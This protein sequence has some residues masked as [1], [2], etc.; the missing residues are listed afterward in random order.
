MPETLDPK[1]ACC[2][3]VSSTCPGFFAQ[4]TGFAYVYMLSH[5]QGNV[6]YIYVCVCVGV[7]ACVYACMYVCTCAC[8]YVCNHVGMSVRVGSR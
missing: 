1:C 8:V 4:R 3:A 2:T 6:T 7:F 5:F